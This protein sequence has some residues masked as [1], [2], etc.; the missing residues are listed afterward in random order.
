MRIYVHTDIDTC[1]PIS[2]CVV[3]LQYPMDFRT[4][5]IRVLLD[6]QRKMSV[7]KENSYN[8]RTSLH[9]TLRI[10][11]LIFY[12]ILLITFHATYINIL[13]KIKINQV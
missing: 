4:L 9:K 13:Q 6:L 1:S 3:Q 2:M 5:E 11:Y 8:V 7:L 10:Y 12:S